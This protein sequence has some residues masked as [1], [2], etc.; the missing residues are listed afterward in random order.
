L[1]ALRSPR[2]AGRYEH[3]VS[4]WRERGPAVLPDRQR[5]R[6]FPRCGRRGGPACR[7][8][9][10]AGVPARGVAGAGAR[11][12]VGRQEARP[13]EIGRRGSAYRRQTWR[14]APP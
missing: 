8:V 4:G 12:A 10:G 3:A 14:T 6:S 5:G 11:H 2:R 7:Q 13:T 9:G 1:R